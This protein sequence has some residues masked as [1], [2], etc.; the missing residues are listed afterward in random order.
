MISKPTKKIILLCTLLSIAIVPVRFSA[1]HISHAATGTIQHLIDKLS[2][3]LETKKQEI[4]QLEAD[5]KKYKD[6]IE[7][8]R[9][10]IDSLKKEIGILEAEISKVGNDIKKTNIQIDTTVLEIEN[11][12][13]EIAHYENEIK[14]QKIVLSYLIADMYERTMDSNLEIFLRNDNLS[15]Y[16]NSQE[17]TNTVEN[18]AKGTL[19]N[20]KDVKFN[21]EKTKAKLEG[22]KRDLGDLKK[23]LQAQKEVL[24]DKKT[25]KDTLLTT[26]QGKEKKYQQIKSDLE[27][28][29]Q[30]VQK[31]LYELEEKIRE[32]VKPKNLPSPGTGVLGW[33][34]TDPVLTQGYG[35]TKETGFQNRWY[36]FHNGIDLRAPTGTPIL[37]AADG[38]IA[39]I[40]N[41]G[42]Y[43][44]GK[45][46]LVKHNNGLSTL[47]G[48]LSSQS[49][50]KGDVV[51][52]G[53]VIGLSG[54]TG[55]ST[56]AHLHFTV[57]DSDNVSIK[58]SSL[59]AG[60][61]PVG[62]HLNPML[63]L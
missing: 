59:G 53:D 8:K 3:E 20:L 48:H 45:W 44:Y 21:L 38:T 58:E 43:A 5:T 51:K 2:D 33:P 35:S 55:Y 46:I 16:Y 15:E 22:K 61:L 14:N 18:N 60:S 26:T 24:D 4:K 37:A 63:Y 17:Y 56:G 12:E 36:K 9:K 52:K 13:A 49:V 34:V 28:K 25:E 6:L 31:E 40:G 42:K 32:A 47:Y 62:Y 50:S 19:D 54:S 29:Q 57:Y 7:Q 27:K 41:N 10:E 11:T 1:M 39:A 23:T 30:D